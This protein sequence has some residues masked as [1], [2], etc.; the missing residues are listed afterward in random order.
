MTRSASDFEHVSG[1]L[2]VESVVSLD[3]S[4]P[5]GAAIGSAN[6]Q[7]WLAWTEAPSHDLNMMSSPDG[8]TF[9]SWQRLPYQSTVPAKNDTLGR[10]GSVPSLTSHND[11]LLLAWPHGPDQR[12]RFNRYPAIMW[13]DE[14]RVVVAGQSKEH[15]V[16]DGLSVTSWR[17]GV[18]LAWLQSGLSGGVTVAHGQAGG[19]GEPHRLVRNGFFGRILAPPDVCAVDDNLLVSWIDTKK[20]TQYHLNVAPLDGSRLGPPIAIPGVRSARI[21]SLAGE[22]AVVWLELRHFCVGFLRGGT[23]TPALRTGVGRWSG[24]RAAICVHDGGLVLAWRSGR[25]IDVAR[26]RRT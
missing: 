14:Q 10:T 22:V 1:E 9:G 12:K 13:G 11:V 8:Q 20:L 24:G 3:I 4:A 21:C 26:I 17:G 19:F 15:R 7:L 16:Y 23:L 25:G 5:Y 18:V 2:S 6:G